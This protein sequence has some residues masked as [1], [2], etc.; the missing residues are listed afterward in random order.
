M[1][2]NATFQSCNN[3]KASFATNT[4]MSGSIE[5][6]VYVPVLDDYHGPYVVTP[7][8]VEQTLPTEDKHMVRDVTVLSVP[9]YE[10]SNQSGITVYI[11][12]N[13]ND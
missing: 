5:S 7:Q 8:T 13:I 3:L 12:E 9:Y 11:A 1:T 6:T 2:L 10:V 4:D